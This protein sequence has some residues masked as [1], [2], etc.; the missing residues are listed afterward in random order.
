MKNFN[1][2]TSICNICGFKP[3][4]NNTEWIIFFVF[5]LNNIVNI[6]ATNYTLWR[7]IDCDYSERW[8]IS[9]TKIKVRSLALS[10]EKCIVKVGQKLWLRDVTVPFCVGEEREPSFWVF[11]LTIIPGLVIFSE[12]RTPRV[13][14]KPCVCRGTVRV[15]SFSCGPGWSS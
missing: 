15:S 4:I 8:S 14:V 7:D 9:Y 10:K 3:D 13:L 2:F 12:E 6:K 5:P 11:T 1:I